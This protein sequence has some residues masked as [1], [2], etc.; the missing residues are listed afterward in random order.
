M[1]DR[2]QDG[3]GSSVVVSRWRIVAF[4]SSYD[5]VCTVS[6]CV[7]I[8]SSMMWLEEERRRRRL[9]GSKAHLRAGMW[10]CAAFTHL[11][12]PVNN[13]WNRCIAIKG[14]G[15]RP[16]GRQFAARVFY[17]Q[18]SRPCYWRPKLAFGSLPSRQN[19]TNSRA[20]PPECS[21]C[22]SVAFSTPTPAPRRLPPVPTLSKSRGARHVLVQRARRC[23]A[24]PGRVLAA[25]QG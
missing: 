5:R 7:P 24:A 21:L 23:H 22:R 13:P 11:L 1:L 12:V 20:T 14:E 9:D 16:L 17:L 4:S 8:T 15:Q 3:C 19:C 25:G 6:L 18:V 2:I 10:G